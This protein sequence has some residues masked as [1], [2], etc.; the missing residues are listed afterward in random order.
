M[1]PTDSTQDTITLKTQKRNPPGTNPGFAIA[2]GLSHQIRKCEN[3]G[4]QKQNPG[5]SKPLFRHRA[6][7]VPPEF[8]TLEQK[9]A[10]TVEKRDTLGSFGVTD[11]QL[12]ISEYQL[13]GL[14]KTAS[15]LQNVRHVDDELVRPQQRFCP[16]RMGRRETENERVESEG[17]LQGQ[18]CACPLRVSC[19]L[20]ACGND[21]TWVGRRV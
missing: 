2:S 10:A 21:C 19:C 17:M 13:P 16:A 9:R 20:C 15:A 7:W 11:I 1:C 5:W 18:F 4:S 12:T 3:F 6:R 14:V 8:A